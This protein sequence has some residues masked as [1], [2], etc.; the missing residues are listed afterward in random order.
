MAPRPRTITPEYQ[1][2]GKGINR[3]RN[4]RRLIVALGFVLTAMLTGDIFGWSEAGH[5]INRVDRLPTPH[6]RTAAGRVGN[7]ARTSPVC[8]GFSRSNASGLNRRRSGRVAVSTS[9][10]LARYRA[11]VYRCRQGEIPSFHLA[12]HQQAAFLE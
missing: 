11:R 5:K 10:H 9:F 7:P 3:P 8:R 1:S 4:Q 6:R 12:L 2:T